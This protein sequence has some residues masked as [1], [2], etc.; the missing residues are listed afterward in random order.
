MHSY[1]L[2]SPDTPSPPDSGPFPVAGLT[3]AEMDTCA[4]RLFKVPLGARMSQQH[5]FAVGGWD[6]VARGAQ[7]DRHSSTV[8][9]GC[10][11]SSLSEDRL[12]C[13]AKHVA[14]LSGCAPLAFVFL[15]LPTRQRG[16]GWS[17]PGRVHY[18]GLRS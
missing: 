11:S 5:F 13:A 10:R 6:P 7:D 3:E 8:A 14:F 1:L 9:G 15:D 16:S 4:E 2:P 12:S 18:V 17:V